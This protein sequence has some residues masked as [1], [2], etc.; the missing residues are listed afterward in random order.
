MK[1]RNSPNNYNIS[2]KSVVSDKLTNKEIKQICL[3]K[4][5]QWKFGIKSQ[6]EWFKNNVKK[7]DFHN[8]LYINSKLVGYTLL[9]KRTC[10]I[11]SY[12]ANTQYLL[13]DTLIID[14][15]YRNKKLS[16]LLMSFNNMIIKESGFF[17]FLIC[18]NELIDFYQKNDW[19]KLNKKVFNVVDHIFLSNGMVFNKKNDNNKYIFYIND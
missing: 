12:K 14:K 19:K 5:K 2:L 13:F 16:N 6:L 15:K 17:S 10:K 8:L 9:R 4:D 7:F 3:L 11:E 1:V 18:N